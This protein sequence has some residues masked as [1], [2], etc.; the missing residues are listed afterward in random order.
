[1]KNIVQNTAVINFGWWHDKY[2]FFFVEEVFSGFQDVL[3]EHALL[4]KSEDKVNNSC[5]IKNSTFCSNLYPL[6]IIACLLPVSF[7]K[8]E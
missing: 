7:L 6:T 3:T 2:S 8:L 4:L 5:C 1:M